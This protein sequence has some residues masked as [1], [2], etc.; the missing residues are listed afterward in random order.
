MKQTYNERVRALAE[1]M[2][3]HAYGTPDAWL[4]FK[5]YARI[6]VAQMA[7]IAKA[8]YLTALGSYKGGMNPYLNEQGLVPEDAQE[9]GEND[10]E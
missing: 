4:E 7:E 10:T 3:I 6:A 2:A 1:K 8:A 5:Y 9:G